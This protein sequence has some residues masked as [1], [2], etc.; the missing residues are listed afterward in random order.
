MHIVR[1]T[2][3]PIATM[4]GCHTQTVADATL[5][6]TPFDV[7][8][9]RLDPGAATAWATRAAPHLVLA[10][11]GSGKLVMAGNT[12]RFAAPCTLQIPAGIE[13]RFVNHAATE[14]QL[15][16]VWAGS[17]AQGIAATGVDDPDPG[18]PSRPRVALSAD[19]R[20]DTPPDTDDPADP[21]GTR[22][23]TPPFH[24]RT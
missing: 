20:P 3:L 2:L 12:Q 9:Q 8:I 15:V 13:H 11:A 1:H 21:R 19:A 24:Q 5:C 14:M 4:D 7:Q 18:P 23:A 22:P 17:A 16:G 6:Q 10:L